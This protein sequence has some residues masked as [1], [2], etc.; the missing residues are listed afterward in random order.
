MDQV[1]VRASVKSTTA[2]RAS[3]DPL[4]KQRLQAALRYQLP[5]SAAVGRAP[6]GTMP[7]PG[8]RRMQRVDDRFRFTERDCTPSMSA[9]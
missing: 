6:I 1:P 2:V 4:C 7:S 5:T 8:Q 3:A 9:A